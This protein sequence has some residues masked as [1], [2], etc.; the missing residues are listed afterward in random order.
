MDEDLTTLFRTCAEGLS[1]A[2]RGVLGARAETAEVLQEAFLKAWRALQGGERPKDLKAWVFVVTL[3]LA[4]DLRRRRLRRPAG[5]PLE[6]ADAMHLTA[7][8]PAPGAGIEQAEAVEAAREAIHGLRDEE[9]E[10]FLLRVSGGLGFDDIAESL[11][12]PTGTAK[13]RMRLA[14]SKLRVRLAAFAPAL[15]PRREMP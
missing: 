15:T 14:L 5:L 4:K 1:G 8:D 9:K 7:A 13:T 10:V 2:V 11:G 3:N 6:E 12:I